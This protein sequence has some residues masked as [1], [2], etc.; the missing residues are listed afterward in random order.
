MNPLRFS[1]IAL[2]VCLGAPGTHA[3]SGSLQ[4]QIQKIVGEV[5]EDRIRSTIARLVSFGTRNT[6]SSQ[7]D[8]ER[9]VG[10]ARKWIFQ[11]LRSYSP[12]LQVRY[13]QWRVKKQGQR[14]V[15]DIDLYNVIAVLPGQTNPEARIVVSAH[16]DSLNLGAP[17]PPAPGAAGERPVEFNW[18]K[19]ID[20]PA[21]GACDDASGIAA[22]MELARVM[23]RYEFEKTLVFIAFAGEEQGLVG[24]TL[25]AAKARKED[26]AIEAVLNN[27]IIGTEVSGDGRTGNSAV[28][29]YGD[30]VLDSPAQQLARYVHA[31]GELYLPQM[32]VNAIYMQDRLGRG[33][34]HSPFQHEG[35]PAVRLSTP[36]EILANQHHATDTLE[37]MSVPYTAR[38]ARVNAAAAASLALAPRT[39][40]VMNQPRGG[41]SGG[42]ANAAAPNR[43]LPMISRG[44]GY[45]AVL[46][47][48]TAG[49]DA[50]LKGYA[51]VMRATTSPFWEREIYVGKVNE[52]T[53]KGVS[54]DE[55]RFG[56]KA[57]GKDGSQSLVAAY[58]YPPRQKVEYQT[59]E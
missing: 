50:N 55:T 54:I 44:A 36:N 15:K 30:D 23:S 29:V 41:G 40:D 1:A 6:L 47:W 56:V 16:Y 13:D 34:D 51:I 45:D 5:S 22:V 25:E 57:I 10:A 52:F 14:I 18:E 37:N 21:P 12:R 28:A 2:A 4:P 27:D 49:S 20:L 39:P 31:I 26:L 17:A 3:D 58:A 46:R 19:N 7:D 43:R 48:R 9:G 33:G 38:V 32:S 53:L 35:Y 42:S 59:I 24:S 8:P 11:E